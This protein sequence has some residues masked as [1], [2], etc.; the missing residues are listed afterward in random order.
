MARV[1]VGGARVSQRSVPS[2]RMSSGMELRAARN[3]KGWDIDIVIEMEEEEETPQPQT[4]AAPSG[5]ET[6][7]PLRNPCPYQRALLKR[8][9]L[10]TTPYTHF[11]D[12]H[13]QP[14]LPQT[15]SQQ[16]SFSTTTDALMDNFSWS[17]SV[18]AAIAPCLPCFSATSNSPSN[19]E[20]SGTPSTN[21]S[22]T[23]L[24]HLLADPTSDVDSDGEALS[25]H[26]ANPSSRRRRRRS[27]KQKKAPKFSL[28]LFGYTFGRQP[29]YLSDDDD[30]LVPSG[31][32]VVVSATA[33]SSTLDSDAAPLDAAAIQR[34]T[35]PQPQKTQEQVEE[36]RR[37]AEEE[38]ERVRAKAERKARRKERKERERDAA[39]QALGGGPQELEQGAGEFEGFQEGTVPYPEDTSY[40]EPPSANLSHDRQ[41][42]VHQQ[43]LGAANAA[44]DEGSG[45]DDADLGGE[46]YTR[47]KRSSVAAWGGSDSNSNSRTSASG[48]SSNPRRMSLPASA[49]FTLNLHPHSQQQAPQRLL[50]A[51]PPSASAYPSTTM[52]T[53][54]SSTPTK[55]S[56]DKSS[57]GASK[58]RRRTST[59]PSSSASATTASER[60]LHSPAQSIS[61]AYAPSPLVIDA[62]AR[63][64]E[65][66]YD[67]E[68]EAAGYMHGPPSA[69]L[70]SAG[71][72]SKSGFPSAG[73]TAS[74]GGRT[75]S[76]SVGKRA[77]AAMDG[78]AL[79]EHGQRLG[80]I[81]Q[82]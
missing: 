62:G 72:S 32:P 17:D 6:Q 24:A 43:Q 7:Q 34:L 73:L 12:F 21:T 41:T 10:T 27:K 58:S 44:L 64:P 2:D 76:A 9:P 63:T 66:I 48:G 65:R 42:F 5:T 47:K 53:L 52:P 59:I 46:L 55:K 40:Y 26:S 71:F 30:D 56:K 33:S 39:L 11:L 67:D 57:S 77:T 14:A 36:E 22:R 23:D 51:G 18:R 60:T 28:T 49:P 45:S 4:V 75:R 19:G 31:R 16:N 38:E 68:Q 29:I 20:G 35:S 3:E 13:L 25:L 15:N 78:R 80:R 70:P 37:M 74:G 50:S 82:E 81:E 8:R 69:G 54:T 79:H 1:T 61:A